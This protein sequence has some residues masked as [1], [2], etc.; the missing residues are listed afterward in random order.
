MTG[1][2]TQRL[3]ALCQ[4]VQHQLEGVSGSKVARRCFRAELHLPSALRQRYSDRSVETLV[5][6]VEELSE[7]FDFTSERIANGSID[8]DADEVAAVAGEWRSFSVFQYP[9]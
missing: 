1:H 9:C 4:G 2:G 3:L 7:I 5:D 6:Q 8:W